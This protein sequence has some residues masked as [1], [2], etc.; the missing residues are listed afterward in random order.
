MYTMIKRESSL[1]ADENGKV[2][3]RVVILVDTVED[4]P[5]AEESWDPGSLAIVA[6]MHRCKILNNGREWA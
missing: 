4:L 1:N 6:D 5:E 2:L 3:Q